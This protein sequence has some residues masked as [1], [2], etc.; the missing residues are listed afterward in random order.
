MLFIGSWGVCHNQGM[1]V[2]MIFAIL[3]YALSNCMHDACIG[4]RSTGNDNLMNRKNQRKYGH[5]F[6]LTFWG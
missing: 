5:V 3:A 2:V 4:K 6:G 1:L